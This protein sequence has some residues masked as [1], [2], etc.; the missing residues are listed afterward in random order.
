[1]VLRF[2]GLIAAGEV[3]GGV[4]GE[5]HIGGNIHLLVSSSSVRQAGAQSAICKEN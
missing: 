2:K 3:T 5:Y 4:H 1:M